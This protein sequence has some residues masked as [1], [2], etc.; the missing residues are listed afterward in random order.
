MSL[1]NKESLEKYFA[2]SRER[3]AKRKIKKAEHRKNSNKRQK[4]MIE[5]EKR[6]EEKMWTKSFLN[7]IKDDSEWYE[8][9]NS[10]D[11]SIHSVEIIS[12]LSNKKTLNDNEQSVL[13]FAFELAYP[14]GL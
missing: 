13:D 9:W 14:N 12:I 2:E 5:I 4:K 7:A 11:I 6:K 10:T 1:R 3:Q 8:H